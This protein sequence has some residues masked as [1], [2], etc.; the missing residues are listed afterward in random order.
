MSHL[1][2]IHCNNKRYKRCKS[3][4]DEWLEKK[5][6]TLNDLRGLPVVIF[7]SKVE[8]DLFCY[9]HYQDKKMGVTLINIMK[10]KLAA[11]STL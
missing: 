11:I 6:A 1:L 8:N 2:G 3:K 9:K 5:E 4:N 7:D 10:Q